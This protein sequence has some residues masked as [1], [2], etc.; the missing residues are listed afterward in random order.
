M[1]RV[2]IVRVLLLNPTGNSP[3][4]SCIW[5]ITSV[6][7]RLGLST[8]AACEEIHAFTYTHRLASFNVVR[9]CAHAHLLLALFSVSVLPCQGHASRVPGLGPILGDE[10]V[11][12]H[13][14]RKNYPG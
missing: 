6:G 13:S 5:M 14:A 1:A 10:L 12:K 2:A 4:T 8:L 11:L 3:I 7:G 9:L